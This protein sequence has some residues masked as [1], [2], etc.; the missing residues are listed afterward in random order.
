LVYC[1]TQTCANTANTPFFTLFLNR[2]FY[3]K[4]LVSDTGFSNW[5]INDPSIAFQSLQLMMQLQSNQINTLV[6]NT[7]FN[8]YQLSVPIVA[9]NVL[10]SASGTL[11]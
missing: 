10:I 8:I 2:I 5:Y 3:M 11:S 7:G 4:H 9:Q 1:D 6:H